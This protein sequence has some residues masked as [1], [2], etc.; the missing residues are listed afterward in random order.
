M[1]CPSD[2]DEAVEDVVQD[3]PEP[4]VLFE[5]PLRQ[6]VSRVFLFERPDEYSPWHDYRGETVTVDLTVTRGGKFNGYSFAQR[7]VFPR[8]VVREPAGFRAY[9]EEIISSLEEMHTFA[10][11]DAN[12]GGNDE[13]EAVE[14]PTDAPDV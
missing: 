7:M 10:Q 4:V 11:D 8:E 12:F 9:M 14:I 5:W 3:P 6:M 2:F 1:S 13:E